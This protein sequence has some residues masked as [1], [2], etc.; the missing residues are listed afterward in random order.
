MQMASESASQFLTYSTCG[1][2]TN[3]R[4]AFIQGMIVAKAAQRSVSVHTASLLGPLLSWVLTLVCVLLQPILPAFHSSYTDDASTGVD[5]E[6]FYDKQATL[7]RI[8]SVI[9]QQITDRNTLLST[10]KLDG[11]WSFF[12]ERLRSD[13]EC[14]WNWCTGQADENG[15]TPTPRAA[16][17]HA[18]MVASAECSQVQECRHRRHRLWVVL[19]ESEVG[20]RV[21]LF[22]GCSLATC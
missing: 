8:S 18:R 12:G 6:F 2:L 20:H 5:M 7:P 17:K 19:S 14:M 21:S 4:I 10:V 15:E 11:L 16:P 13:A 1:G 9:G 3:Q 22:C